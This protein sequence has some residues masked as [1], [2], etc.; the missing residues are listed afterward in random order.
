VRYAML[1]AVAGLVLMSGAARA[2]DYQTQPVG[3]CPMQPIVKSGADFTSCPAVAA[4]GH[5]DA[6]PVYAPPA[7]ASAAATTSTTKQ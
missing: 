6:F 1:A 5:G 4:T 2:Q 7:P 3:P